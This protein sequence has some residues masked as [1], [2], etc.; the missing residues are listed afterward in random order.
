MERFQAGRMGP[1]ELLDVENRWERP[2]RGETIDGVRDEE[3]RLKFRSFLLG[4]TLFS[5]Q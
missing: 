2:I 4:L 1:E 3:L 5:V